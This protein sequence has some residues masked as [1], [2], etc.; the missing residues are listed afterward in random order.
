M[1]NETLEE[2]L[3]E[4]INAEIYSAYLYYS[5]SAYCQSMDLVGMATWFKVQAQEELFHASKFFDYV[6]DRGG[7]VTLKEIK[8]PPVVWDSPLGAFSGA[9]EH[10]Q[11]VTRRISNLVELAQ[12][13]R[14]PTTYNFLQWFVGE[15]VEEE[16]TA[17]QIV[18]QLRLVGSSGS[19]L[20]LLDRELGARTFTM[21]AAGADA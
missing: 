4:Q 18:G 19:G 5:M 16:A 11:E 21:P 3:C 10:E 1:L 14:D 9:L 2:A 13:E 20:Y 6:H 12:K 15:Q 7:R 17:S 8:A